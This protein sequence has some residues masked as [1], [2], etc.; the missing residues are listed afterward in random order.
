MKEN[1]KDL[2]YDDVPLEDGESRDPPKTDG[3]EVMI[4]QQHPVSKACT[5]QTYLT[6]E[7]IESTM[8]QKA[9]LRDL[10]E[11]IDALI[12]SLER[13]LNKNK[14]NMSV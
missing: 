14:L 9:N 1:F 6:M 4:K 12:G 13:E 8:S 11:S 7:T 3:A 2:D 10:Q 5:F